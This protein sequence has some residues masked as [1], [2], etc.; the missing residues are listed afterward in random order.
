[1]P[2]CARNALPPHMTIE[3]SAA[4]SQHRLATLARESIIGTQ[5]AST[6]TLQR[7]LKLGFTHA[8]ALLTLFEG[9]LVSTRGPDGNRIIL[10]R[11][12]DI[13]HANHPT[14][15]YWITPG[16]LMAGEYPGTRDTGS[17]RSKIARLLETGITAFLDLTEAGELRAYE[18][19]LM[20]VAKTQQINC[21]Y[22][23]M[24]IRDVSTPDTRQT[25]AAILTQ[26]EQWLHEKRTVYVHCWGGVGRTGTVV[27]CHLVHNGMSGTA[28]LN[29]IK[30][31]WTRMGADKQMRHP[32]SPETHAQRDYVR[33]WSELEE[34]MGTQ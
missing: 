6:A 8:E 4:A 33:V 19:E 5:S 12:L 3:P 21:T 13:T 25:M 17:T 14:N 10:P 2:R 24:P 29:H 7:R 1:M 20:E 26:I 27:G 28:A 31:L 11:L 22:R 18:G 32:V 34:A 9:D 15:T 23:R 16:A 30:L